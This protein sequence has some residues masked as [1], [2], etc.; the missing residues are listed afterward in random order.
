MRSVRLAVC[1]T[2][3]WAPAMAL[4]TAAEVKIDP[5]F[6]DHMVL[7]RDM[8]VPVWGTGTPGDNITVSFG[9]QK[10]AGTVAKDGKWMI[11]LDPLKTGKPGELIL[12]Q[13]TNTI[14]LKDVLVGEVW[15]GSGQS[16]M[17]LVIREG[18]GVDPLLAAAAA[19][20]Y[21]QIRHMT[22]GAAGKG[23]QEA[24]PENMSEFSALLFTFGVNLHKELDVPVGLIAAAVGCSCA[25][26]WVSNEAIEADPVIKEMRSH[27]GQEAVGTWVG[28]RK[29]TR[30]L[31]GLGCFYESRIRPV[32]PY[33]IRGV[34]W[35]QGEC[36][37]A[38]RGTKF[39]EMEL[40]TAMGVLIRGWRKQWGQG[41]F[42][43][44]C[45]QKP[46]GPGCAWDDDDP[47]T[48]SARKFEPL[49]QAVPETG[50][51]DGISLQAVTPTSE[52]G[53]T[54]V[55]HA[56]G[57]RAVYTP[58][59][60]FVGLDS[61]TYTV[62]DSTGAANKSGFVKVD[63]RTDGLAV[64]IDFEDAEKDGIE[65]M[66]K[67]GD[68]RLWSY[69]TMDNRPEA[70]KLTYHFRNRG[71]YDGGRATAHWIN[72]A[73]VPGVRGMGLLN[74]VVGGDGKAQVDLTSGGDPGCES[75]SASVWVLYP[76]AVRAGMIL[77]KSP[78]GFKTLTS[79]WAI[80]CTGSAFSFFGSG[81]RLSLGGGENFE[82]HSEDPIQPD[83]WY[84]LVMVMDRGA[85][86]LRAYVNNKEV[87]ASSTS[88]NIPAGVIEY[89]APLRL[90]NGP[91]WKS[92][93]AAP[94]LVDEVKI[95]TAALTP[96]QVAALY[97]EGKDAMVPDLKG[98]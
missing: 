71:P 53:G 90:F 66:R 4:T 92:W 37:S 25:G 36:N 14:T 50:N 24:R 94:M 29:H 40:S 80:R 12:L 19:N 54:V 73:P 57:K 35:D 11:H 72:Y 3:V 75:L 5:A 60:G 45:V 44:I 22:T 33:A 31:G 63:V 18:I 15:L 43:F 51:G 97:A 70:Q 39:W 95:L 6:G 84:H 52:K 93:G 67:A 48:R 76:Q 74:P 81:V 77:C 49:P 64:H 26:H 69:D 7:Q 65:W 20:S 13:G 38:L 61:F 42:P 96:Q 79:G 10:K 91:G 21:P 98:K 88:P 30:R 47:V 34:V 82:I 1:L 32:M 27:P 85:A 59:P 87:T 58:K 46:S 2:A 89:H 23:W 28:S 62:V 55:V 83:T 8:K 41:E 17:G 68:W 9:G 86:K 56:D 78:C 16:N